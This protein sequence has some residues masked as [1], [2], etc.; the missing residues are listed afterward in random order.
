MEQTFERFRDPKSAI[1]RSYRGAFNNRI[2]R[3]PDTGGAFRVEGVTHHALK[4]DCFV[5]EDVIVKREQ[6]RP[7]PVETEAGVGGRIFFR[8]LYS[9]MTTDSMHYRITPWWQ[10][11]HN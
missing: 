2:D 8:N 10:G 11:A 5:S 1:R 9:F 6:P 3:F 7:S 4:T